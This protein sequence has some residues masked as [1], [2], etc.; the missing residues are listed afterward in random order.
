MAEANTRLSDVQEQS[1]SRSI[2]IAGR[3]I[4][5]IVAA[6][7]AIYFGNLLMPS[8]EVLGW[9]LVA[10]G[11][12]SALGGAAML[13]VAANRAIR[14]QRMDSIAFPCPYCDAV[15]HFLKAPS[16]DFACEFCQRMVHFRDGEPVPVQTIVCQA[17]RAEHRVAV[18]AERYV[19]DRCNRPL[20]IM[21]QA[22]SAPVVAGLDREQV[23]AQE[24]A[25]T[26]HQDVLVS[27]FDPR[28]EQEVVFRIQDLLLVNAVEARRLLRT[29]SAETPLVVSYDVP[30]LKAASI[31]RQLTDL[32]AS[33]T[34]RAAGSGAGAPPRP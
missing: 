25:Q 28:R 30:P 8:I 26:Q 29:A 20:R 4:A 32:G 2:G 3:G 27:G 1:W 11:A 10:L 14:T 24:R 34:A 22:L 23:L 9:L 19:C 15:N 16:E 13:F 6:C 21:Q 12:A 18:T 5:L 31:R 17:C 7:I 33:A